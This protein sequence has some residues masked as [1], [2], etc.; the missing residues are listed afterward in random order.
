MCGLIAFVAS[1]YETQAEHALDALADRGPDRHSVLRVGEATLGHARLSVIDLETGDQPMQ[2]A[3]GRY[4]IAYNGEIYNFRQ[5]RSQLEALGARFW[6]Q[7]DTEVLL[8]AYAVWGPEFVVKLDGMFAFA[9]WDRDRRRM[10]CARDRMGIK[11]LFYSFHQGLT[12]AST[13]SPFLALEGFPRRLDYRALRDYLAVQAVQWPLTF[14]SDVAQ[15][16]PAATLTYDAATGQH[17]LSS[18]WEM[19]GSTGATDLDE[20]VR[21]A[22]RLLQESVQAQTVA[23]VPVGAFLSGGIDSSLIVHYLASGSALAVNTFSVRFPGAQFDETGAALEVARKYGTRHAVLE[24]RDITAGEFMTAIGALDQPLADPAYLPLSQVAALAR[25]SVKVALSGDGADELFGGYGRFLKSESSYPPSWH[26][27]LLSL[28]MERGWLPGAVLRRTLHGKL[29]LLY[30]HVEVG[31]WKAGRKAMSQYVKPGFLGY[32]EEKDTVKRWLETAARHSDPISTH[33]LMR[34]DLWSYLTDNCLVKGDRASMRHAL[35]L[36]VP[37]LGNAMID[38]GLSIPPALHFADGRKTVLRK[39]AQRHLPAA[40]WDRPKH[41]FT[42]PLAYYFAGAWRDC[43]NDL[44]DQCEA[45]APFLDAGMVR[46]QVQASIVGKGS[47]RLAYTFIVLLGW[48][49]QHRVEFQ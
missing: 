45:L 37:F 28:A 30:D 41:G 23:D 26:K 29:A 13:L 46:H 21:Q 44:L 33:G 42:V 32:L 5:L 20:T 11:P 15:L 43:V 35:E 14:M 9:L 38:L 48:L 47:M 27:S 1:V 40:V 7:S 25:G 16:P 12:L 31:P 24:A 19:P 49:K 4:C 6:T 3:D 8:H 10:F 36:R 34:A 18:F 22:D 2:S 17:Q 39:L